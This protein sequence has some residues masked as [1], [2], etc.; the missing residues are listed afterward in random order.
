M[1]S[2]GWGSDWLTV[3]SQTLCK[4]AV[5]SLAFGLRKKQAL[6]FTPNL[7]ELKKDL[8]EVE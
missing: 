7:N 5:T 2:S 3:A 1:S 4:F 8:A 6:H